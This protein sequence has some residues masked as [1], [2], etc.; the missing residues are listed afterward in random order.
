MRLHMLTEAEALNMYNTYISAL[1]SGIL[2]IAVKMFTDCESWV[3]EHPEHKER[4]KETQERDRET[5]EAENWREWENKRERERH[6]KSLQKQ[7]E[8]HRAKLRHQR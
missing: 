7:R 8:R 1:K 5:V 2:D 3:E 4:E 6:M